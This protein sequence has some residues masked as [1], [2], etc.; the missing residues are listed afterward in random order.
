[1]EIALANTQHFL[2]QKQIEMVKI[3]KDAIDRC[4]DKAFDG[5]TRG[6]RSCLSDGDDSDNADYFGYYILKSKNSVRP[7]VVDMKKSPIT[8]R[9]NLIDS[10]CYVNTIISISAFD[11]KWG[12]LATCELRGV[13]YVKPGQTFGASGG[14]ACDP[15]DFGGEVTDDV[16]F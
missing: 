5:Q 15:D 16:P 11:C 10:G 3:V 4:V 14:Q 6:V 1:M 2:F 8:E 9:D 13:Q 7:T 12:K